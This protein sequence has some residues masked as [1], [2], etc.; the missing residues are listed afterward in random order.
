KENLKDKYNQVILARD[1]PLHIT[2]YLA[3]ND[4]IE[5]F[6]QKN[7]SHKHISHHTTLR[8]EFKIPYFD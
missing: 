3:C 8:N 7:H 1:T 4:N 5:L 6:K 2:V